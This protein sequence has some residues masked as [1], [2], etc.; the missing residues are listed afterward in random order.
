MRLMACNV[1]L[2]AVFVAGA[3]AQNVLEVQMSGQPLVYTDNG[4]PYG[5]GLRV[6]AAEVLET[7]TTTREVIDT[8][9]NAYRGGVALG[10][11]IAQHITVNADGSPKRAVRVAAYGNW[12]RAGSTTAAPVAGTFK[13]S[14]D[15][16]AYLYQTTLSDSLGLFVAAAKQERVMIGVRWERGTERIY[17]GT[18]Q[19]Q[20]S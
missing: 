1:L 4:T 8:S 20:P 11:L 16:G 17:A 12:W 5:C 2:M 7:G 15:K 19:L 3:H 10:K 9:L 6:V 18:I 14:S 13:Q